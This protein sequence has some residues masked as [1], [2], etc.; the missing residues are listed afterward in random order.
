LPHPGPRNNFWLKIN[1]WFEADLVQALQER[2]ASSLEGSAC[3][4]RRHAPKT[5]PRQAQQPRAGPYSR[6]ARI[7]ALTCA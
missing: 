2:V 3:S 5:S 1:P 6:C 4:P 7:T